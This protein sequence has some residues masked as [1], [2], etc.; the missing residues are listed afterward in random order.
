MKFEEHRD[1]NR[2]K[3]AFDLLSNCDGTRILDIGCGIDALLE[4]QFADCEVIGSDISPSA[5]HNAKKKAPRSEFILADI[6]RLPIK[7]G[8]IDNVAMMAVLGGV[9]QGEEVAAFREAKRVLRSGRYLVLLVSQ[10]CQP[11]SLLAPDRL[12]GGRKWRHFNLQLLQRQL[13]V[14]GFYISRVIFTGGML[15]LIESMVTFF[16]NMLWQLFTRII[17]RRSYSPSLHYQWINRLIG[18]EY[19]PF[20]GRMK[21]LARFIYIVAQKI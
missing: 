10:K 11:Y 19:R 21:K 18:W 3:V 9:P 7:N 6:R 12:F 20:K 16:W 4:Q 14:N 17:I 1:Y 15:S 2:L 5:L 13:E 8:C